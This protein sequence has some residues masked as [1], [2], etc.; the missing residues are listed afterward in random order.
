MS[1]HRR[2]KPEHLETLTE[3][4]LAGF[5]LHRTFPIFV[6]YRKIGLNSRGS[7]YQLE[8]SP[9]GHFPPLSVTG[10]LPTSEGAIA[11]WLD[12]DLADCLTQIIV[13]TYSGQDEYQSL[14]LG[15]N[16]KV[17]PKGG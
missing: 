5:R 14:T 9:L 12:S 15:G 2:I 8:L 7:R 4:H 16:G 6:R 11:W 1:E 17:I 3:H 13:K 10:G